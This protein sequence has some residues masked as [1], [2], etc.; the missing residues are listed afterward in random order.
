[1]FRGLCLWYS[2]CGGVK[3]I[4]RNKLMSAASVGIVA[5][6]LALFGVFLLAELDINSVL[7]D[8]ENQC[9]IN[10][11][12]SDD[13][14]G[15]N[16]NQI[17]DKLSEIQGVK[18]VRFLSKE[19][20][21]ELARQTAYKDREYLI[22]DL[23][24]DDNPLRDSYVLTA[25][26][27]GKSEEIAAEAAKIIGVDEVVNLQ[28]MVDKIKRLSMSLRKAGALIMLVLAVIAMFIIINT[29]K[30]GLI[31][32]GRE[33]SIMRFVGASDGYICG[34]FMFEGLILGV[35]GAIIAAIPILWAYSVFVSKADVILGLGFISLPPVREVWHI[36]AV[37]FLAIGA[38]IGLIGSGVSI[39]KYLKA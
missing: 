2:L 32:R 19:E 21:I 7:G 23:T 17:Y 4:Y 25:D 8:I 29:I 35:L 20:R 31:Y 9:E 28:Q 11:Y 27:I 12:I 18:D 36:L 33:I 26:D 38:G 39:R 13:A 34:P 6:S 1:M 3:N 30:L 24:G 10:V 37:W 22:D 5:A 16:L 14:D 15:S